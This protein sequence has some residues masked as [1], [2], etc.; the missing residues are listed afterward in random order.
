MKRINTKL[1]RTYSFKYLFNMDAA[2]LFN[3]S[4][5]ELPLISVVVPVFNA[6]KY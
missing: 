6:S 3:K 1:A 4:K 2:E 5:G